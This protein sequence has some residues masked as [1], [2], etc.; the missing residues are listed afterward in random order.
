MKI[1]LFGASGTIGQRITL[2][3]LVRGHEV[4]ALTRHPENFPI[5]HPRLTVARADV[6]DASSVAEAVKGADV[7]VNAT[8]A[9]RND[10][11]DKMAFFVE[12]TKA[13]I[14]GVKRAGAARLITVGGAGSLEVAPG[15]LLA[16]TPEFPDIFKPTA[17]A[18]RASLDIYRGADL[19]WTF[20]SP[21]ALIVPGRR[22]GKYRTG[23]DQLLSNDQGE[24]YISAEDYA[25]ALL[26]EIEHPQFERRRFTA[27]SLEK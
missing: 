12:S 23:T 19:N 7:V 21:S 5:A 4:K 2:E 10:N 18:Q 6:L 15:V 22:T 20:F 25:V 26:D 1:A 13:V 17:N 14:E 16:D 24:S 8:G 9:D 3:A 11:V 27:V